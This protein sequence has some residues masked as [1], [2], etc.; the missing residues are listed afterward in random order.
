MVRSDLNMLVVLAAKERTETDYKVLL[1]AADL[2][3]SRIIPVAGGFSIIEAS[4][5]G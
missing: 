3:M 5:S 1:E 4:A 2:G